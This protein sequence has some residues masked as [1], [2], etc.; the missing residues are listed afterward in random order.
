[1]KNCEKSL[2]KF[3]LSPQKK[4]RGFTLIELLIV[5]AILA[6][7]ATVVLLVINPVQM[8]AQ[9]RDSQRIYDVNTLSNAA[10]LYLT[11]VNSPDLDVTGACGINF[12]ATVDGAASRFAVA[13]PEISVPATPRAITGSGWVPVNFGDISGG[14][15]ISS[16]PIDPTN[17]SA[18][19]YFYSYSCDS[20]HKWYEF[21]AHME[22]DRYK[23]G[24]PDDVESTDGG[25]Q[26]NV[27]EVG[28]VPSLA[29]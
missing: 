27:Y 19:N 29:L 23:N 18:N 1:M 21:D 6:I 26:S 22:S 7:L 14:S 28:N 8:F 11:T 12:W 20:T 24:G 10:A 5:I 25:S 2:I 17:T 9:A 15:P 4:A 16:L 13:G 3:N